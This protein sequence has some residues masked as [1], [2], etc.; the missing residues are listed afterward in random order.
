MK[1][2]VESVIAPQMY[3]V[4][5]E[6]KRCCDD[7]VHWNLDTAT[8]GRMVHYLGGTV[9]PRYTNQREKVHYSGGALEP[10]HTN[11]R[12]NGALFRGLTGA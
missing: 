9:E 3:D 10:R 12:K 6:D 7:G 4:G 1:A 8:R 11:Q 5:R 2:N